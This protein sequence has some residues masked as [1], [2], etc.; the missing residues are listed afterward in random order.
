MDNVPIEIIGVIVDFAAGSE[1]VEKDVPHQEQII[2]SLT[3]FSAVNSRF[4]IATT[5]SRSWHPHEEMEVFEDLGQEGPQEE[6]RLFI[7]MPR[8]IKGELPGYDRPGLQRLKSFI[9]GTHKRDYLVEYLEKKAI[10]KRWKDRRTWSTRFQL[11]NRLKIDNFLWFVPGSFIFLYTSALDQ[12][13]PFFPSLAILTVALAIIWMQ[14][15]ASIFHLWT[16]NPTFDTRHKKAIDLLGPGY[17]TDD[18][19]SQLVKI[20]IMRRRGH[21][22]YAMLYLFGSLAFADVLLILQ[23]TL[24][25]LPGI[26]LLGMVPTIATLLYRAI[27]NRSQMR[28]FI[29]ITMVHLEIFLFL[30]AIKSSH[31][32]N[33]DW[34][35]VFIPCGTLLA[36]VIVC[37]IYLIVRNGQPRVV[38]SSLGRFLLPTSLYMSIALI[39]ALKC[40]DIVSWQHTAIWSALQLVF[41]IVLPILAS[42]SWKGSAK[43][44]SGL[45]VALLLWQMLVSTAGIILCILKNSHLL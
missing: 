1:V 31:W 40:Y 15:G 5:R 43:M 29:I 7:P 34:F 13:L 20:A 42:K 6:T 3:R 4:Y 8:V 37:S 35:I 10:A 16:F 11:I 21:Q 9:N 33:F 27:I 12:F 24:G 25:W 38:M 36:S 23:H 22:K 45:F 2:R 41:V 32:I 26:S 17:I 30:L 39:Y 18:K 19:I 14:I 44:K 28:P